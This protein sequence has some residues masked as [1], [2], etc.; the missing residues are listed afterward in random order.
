MKLIIHKPND[1][2]PAPGAKVK[3]TVTGGAALWR[4]FKKGDGVQLTNG[5]VEIPLPD[6]PANGQYVLWVEATAVSPALRSIE[7][8]MEYAGE[9]TTVKATGIWAEMSR[10][11]A[12]GKIGLNFDGFRRPD[13]VLPADFDRNSALKNLYQKGVPAQVLGAAH[14][15]SPRNNIMVMEFT[16]KPSGLGKYE[17]VVLFDISRSMR[18]RTW[19][20]RFLPNGTL[21]PRVRTLDEPFPLPLDRPNDDGRASRLGD[22]FGDEDNEPT[23]DHI[24]VWDAPGFPDTQHANLAIKEKHHNM[25]EFVRVL[26]RK[27]DNDRFVAQNG[28]VQGS[29][30]SEFTPWYSRQIWARAT[31]NAPWARSAAGTNTIAV[32]AHPPIGN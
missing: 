16:V 10:F 22:P 13:S 9:P 32:G 12:A 30:A 19:E 18:M 3:L 20:T 31:P 5:S 14:S 25:W 28:I 7:I 26:I 24:Y 6:F 8:K 15:P 21:G 29:R 4:T 1:P 11:L 27:S 17:N 23:N 2:N